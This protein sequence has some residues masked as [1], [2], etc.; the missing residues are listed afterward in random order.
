MS[1]R[2]A[3]VSAAGSGR[4]G[5]VPVMITAV[6]KTGP[7]PVRAGG[8]ELTGLTKTFRTQRGP[9]HAVRAIDINIAPGETVALLGPNGAGK[10]TTIDMLLGLLQPDAGTVSVFGDDACRARSPRACRRAC[11]RSAAWS[12]YLTV[13]ELLDDGREPVPEPAGGRRGHRADPD[14][15][16]R[17]PAHQ[18]AVRRPDPAAALRARHRSAT[19]TCSYWTSRPS[20]WTSRRAVTSGRPCGDFTTGGKTVRV[21]DALSRGGRRLRRPDHPHGARPSRR[22]RSVDR[23]QGDGRAAHDPRDP[24]RRRP[25]RARARCPA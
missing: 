16:P 5:T 19:P 6:S 4:C 15:R 23:D 10:S 2:I 9:V 25:R 18:Q 7:N 8:I 1:A 14:Q 3:N 12:Q 11:C 17:R 13:R 24:A 21:R 22:R 20:R